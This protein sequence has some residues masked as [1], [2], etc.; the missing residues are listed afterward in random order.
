MANTERLA[1]LVRVREA[2]NEVES[3]L[4]DATITGADRQLLERLEGLLDQVEDDLILGDLSER[5]DEM[6]AE[7]AKLDHVVGQMKKAAQKIQN[8]VD[9][10]DKA[11]KALKILA[12]IAAKAAAIP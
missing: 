8:I 2:N 5:V 9:G 11:A 1:V 12:D 7:S 10:V 3:L 6:E 4:D